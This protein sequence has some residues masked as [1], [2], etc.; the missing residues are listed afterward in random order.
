MCNRYSLKLGQAGGN[1]KN[2]TPCLRFSTP[3]EFFNEE[4]L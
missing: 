2:K 4:N 3:H 1:Q